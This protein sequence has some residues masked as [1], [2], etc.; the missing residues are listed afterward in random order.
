MRQ[1][2]PAAFLVLVF[3]SVSC[4][5]TKEGVEESAAYP[6]VI[7][8]VEG[9]RTVT[10]PDFPKE[11]KIHFTLTEELTIGEEDALEGGV[12]NR[13]Q[14]LDV[15]SDGNIYVMD[16]GDTDIKIFSPDGTLIRTVG[17]KGQGPGEFDIP[18]SFKLSKDNKIFLLSGSQHRFS[19]IETTGEYITGFQ[20][21]AYPPAMDIDSLNRVFYSETL[22][23]D[24]TLT[25]DYQKV[26]SSF[27]LFRRDADGQN[28]I[29]LGEFRDRVSMKR[30]VKS[31]SGTG[32]M[33]GMSREAYTTCWL[34]GPRDRI[35]IGYNKDYKI[36]VYDPDWNLLFRF[37][38][39]FTPIKH[40]LYKPELGHPE[41]Y[42]A[43]SDWR[44]FFDD[45]GNL[46][47][48][49][50]LPEGVEEHAYDVFSPEGIYLKQVWVPT[51]LNLVRGGKA[52]SIFRT[53]EEYLVVKRF[54][55]TE[56]DNQ[57]T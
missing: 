41:Y 49:L 31:A 38:R 8:N 52:Y 46:W 9:V 39:T 43:F 40:P 36:D 26:E 51:T 33:G 57:I 5:P 14:F 28:K 15:D 6:A 50:Y 10:N 12:L 27:A 29:K 42:P 2:L 23:P 20:V 7:E 53:E 3:L 55:M 22:P 21:E 35:Y 30:A 45:E 47:L 24:Y 16:W 37:G 34:V 17:G 56:A 44:K 4:G 19:V 32:I 48:E 18:A 13:P 1:S 11:G 25:E 54:F